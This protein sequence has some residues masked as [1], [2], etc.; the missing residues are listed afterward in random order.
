MTHSDDIRDLTLTLDVLVLLWFS[1]ALGTYR[2][3]HKTNSKLWESL[4]TV[5]RYVE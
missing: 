4:E 3:S 2:Q 1:F 5:M